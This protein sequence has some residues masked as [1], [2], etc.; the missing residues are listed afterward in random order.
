MTFRPLLLA[1]KWNPERN[2]PTGWWMSDK[3]D[4][5]RAYWDGV[6][7]L[8]SRLGNPFTKAPAKYLELL[9]R[10][11]PLDGELY[12][13]PGRFE[14]TVRAVKGSAGWSKL[15]Y[16]AFDAPMGAGP[17]PL[18]WLEFETRIAHAAAAWHDF[19]GQELCNGRE[20]L[21][22]R[23]AQAQAEGLEGVM[24]RAPRSLYEGNRSSTLL[25]VKT[26][27]D[28]EAVVLKVV[29][30]KGKHAGRM[31][32]LVCQWPGRPEMFEVGTGFSDVQRAR[33]DRAWV[34]KRITIRYQELTPGRGV[35]R[36]PSFVA[37]RDYE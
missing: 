10:G 15:R 5:I 31:G 8:W 28:A 4:G 3:L 37:V 11:V 33:G 35:P 22:Q 34:G 17:H 36:F 25:K 13:G 21:E 30:G 27:Q 12:L 7:T 9:P 18:D 29:P 20:H 32:A 23:L 1:K 14:D 24:L 26:F 2:D 16:V 19:A 6:G